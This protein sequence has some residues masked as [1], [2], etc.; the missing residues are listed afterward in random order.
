[1]SQLVQACKANG[2]T[3]LVVVHEHRGEPGTTVNYYAVNQLAS[4]YIHSINNNRN[5]SFN[6]Y[7]YAV[8]T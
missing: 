1:M 8:Q 4:H 6:Y 7:Y 2:V 3:D 5:N